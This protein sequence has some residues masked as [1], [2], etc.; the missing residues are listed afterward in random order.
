MGAITVDDVIAAASRIKDKVH[1]TPV[2]SCTTL[3][4]LA[5]SDGKPRRLLFKCENLQKTGSFKIRGA[6]NALA[7][8]T[9]EDLARGVVAH[10]SGNHAQAIA[11][12]AALIGAQA[13]VVMPENAPQVKKDAVRG[14]GADVIECESTIKARE[15]TC[16]DIIS[17]TGATFVH[18]SNDLQVMAGQGTLMLEFLEQAAELGDS[19]AVD[20]MLVPVGG[21]G[22]ISGCSVACKSLSPAT[23]VFGAEPALAGDAQESLQKRR[24]VPHYPPI[25]CADGLLTGLGTNT[26][27]VVLENVDQIFTVTE[28][29]I[30]QAMK[31]VWERMKQIIEPSAAVGVAVALYNEDF[32]RLDDIHTV[33][34]VLCGGNVQLSR[35]NELFESLRT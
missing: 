14:Y 4:Q 2:L 27:P 29:Q 1:R 28:A 30:I 31:L 18:P 20:V 15:E 3:D 5:S 25:S 32:R 12:A 35:A 13:Y 8:M 19:L 16:Q 24:I 11:S 23:R 6:S 34:I 21:G 26:F 9:S 22:M 17:R 7:Q 33:G 10:S